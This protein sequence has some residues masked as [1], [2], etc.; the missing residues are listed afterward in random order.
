MNFWLL[1]FAIDLD[2]R[3]KGLG[4]RCA[5]PNFAPDRERPKEHE[6]RLTLRGFIETHKSLSTLTE[7][8]RKKSEPPIHVCIG[9]SLVVFREARQIFHNLSI[10]LCNRAFAKVIP[11]SHR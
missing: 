3:I 4:A 5:S 7:T 1:A 8:T 10:A 11:L 2:H 9:I 6:E